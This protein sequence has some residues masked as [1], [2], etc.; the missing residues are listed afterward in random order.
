MRA[1][2]SSVR[3]ARLACRPWGG[4]IC[5]LGRLRR[6]A[7]RSCEHAEHS[8]TLYGS[9]LGQPGAQARACY[10][11]GYASDAQD[12]ASTQLL[13]RPGSVGHMQ[14]RHPLCDLVT[15]QP[16]SHSLVRRSVRAIVALV[17]H[18]SACDAGG[19][20]RPVVRHHVCAASTLDLAPY[21]YVAVAGNAGLMRVVGP[22]ASA[23]TPPAGTKSQELSKRR[24]PLPPHGRPPTTLIVPSW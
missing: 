23:G 5:P 1:I 4:V 13:R 2:R 10:C 19:L 15:T 21:D 3:E 18:A 24:P 16:D 6:R 9:S 14:Q 22:S 12:S 17:A 7:S 20:G 11:L 8:E